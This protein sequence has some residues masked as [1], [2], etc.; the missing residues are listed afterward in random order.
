[1]AASRDPASEARRSP[2][3]SCSATPR[4]RPSTSCSDAR[5]TAKCSFR[6]AGTVFSNSLGMTMGLIFVLSWLVQFVTG[7]SVYN[8][9]QL[10]NLQDP[11]GWGVTGNTSFLLTSGALH[12]R[13][14]SRSSS[15]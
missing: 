15:P 1:M 14:G 5:R 6:L 9:E 11:V 12:F 13:T 3:R 10:K 8:E 2:W 4:R 7:N